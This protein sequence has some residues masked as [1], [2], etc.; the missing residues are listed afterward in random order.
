MICVSIA[1]HLLSG[2]R[3]LFA[4]TLNRVENKSILRLNLKNFVLSAIE[5]LNKS[6]AQLSSLQQQLGYNRKQP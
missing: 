4:V 1:I 5:R 6:L 2:R 3:G